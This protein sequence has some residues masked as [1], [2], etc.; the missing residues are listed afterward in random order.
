MSAIGMVLRR[1]GLKFTGTD[2][3]I[4]EEGTR[5]ILQA[6]SELEKEGVESPIGGP[7]IVLLST[8]GISDKGRDIP[9]AMIPLY[10]WMLSVPHEDK[11]KMEDVMVNGEGKNRKWVLIRP[12]FLGDGEGKGL[13]N[14][15]VSAEIAGAKREEVAIGYAIRREDV[16]EW[17]VESCAKGRDGTWDGKI[18]TLTY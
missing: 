14:V 10:H 7:R 9:I 12:S 5:S 16:G 2:I 3:H 18:V 15:R 13:Q 8:T 17:I 4:C 1:E 11:K 6:L